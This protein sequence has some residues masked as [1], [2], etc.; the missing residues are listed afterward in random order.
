MEEQQTETSGEQTSAPKADTNVTAMKPQNN[1][2]FIVTIVALAVIIAGGIY[3]YHTYGFSLPGQKPA[4]ATV[5]APTA[6]DY[7]AVVAVINGEEVPG[8]ELAQSAAQAEQTAV[9]QGL[10]PKD[11]QVRG[12]IDTQ[13]MD[14]LINTHLLS[15]AAKAA[16]IVISD[17]D[18]Q[19]Q[20]TQLETQYGGAD[21]LHKQMTTLGISDESLR[22]DIKTQLAIEA[23]LKTTPEF[24]SITVT[25]AEVSS[26]YDTY[27]AQN[28]QLPPL[29]QI[30]SQ[31]KDQLTTQ[32][33][34]TATGVIIDKLRASAQIEK[35]V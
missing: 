29:D 23:Y 19:T 3:A 16:G 6:A 12:E 7:P 5:I 35:K 20:I 24:S 27:S 9:Q 15:Q 25:D 34:Q 32:K 13:A 18:V 21:A 28:A 10:D 26:A 33:Q 8:S 22:A 14:V 17:T 2:R 4:A 11:P 1:M 30:S 31:I